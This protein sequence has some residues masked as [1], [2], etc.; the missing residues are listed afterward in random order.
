MI[1]SVF[2][3]HVH[4]FYDPVL[5]DELAELM[6]K[7]FS[8]KTNKKIKWVT[9]MYSD[10]REARNSDHD[11]ILVDLDDVSSLSIQNLSFALCRFITEIRKIEGTDFPPRTLLSDH[12]L[13]PVQIGATRIKRQIAG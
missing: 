9:K 5:E 3:R 6:K 13:F 11:H 4:T 1:Y 12:C 10:W 8:P 7:Q 2:Y